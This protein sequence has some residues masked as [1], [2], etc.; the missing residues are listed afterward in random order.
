MTGRYEWAVQGHLGKAQGSEGVA[1]GNSG[2]GGG[3]EVEKRGDTAS[4]GGQ[5]QFVFRA[6][7]SDIQGQHRRAGAQ[8]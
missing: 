2:M 4:G 6:Q 8:L 1:P 5:E 3:G 7:I